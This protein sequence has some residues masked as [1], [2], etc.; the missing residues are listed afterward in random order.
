MGDN[1]WNGRERNHLLVNTGAGFVEASSALGFD[2]QRD[3][4]GMA[5]ADFD[6][7]GDIDFVIN[8]YRAPAALWL[9]Q[10]GNK[11]PTVAV[12]AP[13]GTRLTVGNQVRW[14]GAGHGYASQNS[15]ELLFA[16]AKPVTVNA[17]WPDR[18]T[19]TF[20]PIEPGQRVS[21]KPTAAASHAKPERPTEAGTPP[22]VWPTAGFLWLIVIG[23]A[24]LV[25]KR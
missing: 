9:N 19:E 25:R 7:D 11:N 15:T 8:N 10:I 2:D 12:R 4:R 23:T 24:M 6:H 16:A 21:I 13:I 22:W 17:L 18:R 5:A 20:G 1:S 3:A 14:V